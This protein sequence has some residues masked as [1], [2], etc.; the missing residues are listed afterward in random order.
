MDIIEIL[1]IKNVF[2]VLVFVIMLGY[3]IF[4]FV[5]MLRIRILADTLK[6]Q[7]SGVVSLLAKLHFL[8]TFVGSILVGFLI[9]F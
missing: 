5:L 1:T 6:T 8:M 4:S 9:L 3:C 7:K 2:R